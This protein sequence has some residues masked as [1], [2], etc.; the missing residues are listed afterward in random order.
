MQGV[1]LLKNW[2]CV[3]KINVR[4]KGRPRVAMERLVFPCGNLKIFKCAVQS[5]D[6]AVH[7]L[8]VISIKNFSIQ[9]DLNSKDLL[10]DLAMEGEDFQKM[11]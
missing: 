11:V 3:R 8:W 2:L 7:I 5:F 9:V 4:L 1:L 10:N 6:A